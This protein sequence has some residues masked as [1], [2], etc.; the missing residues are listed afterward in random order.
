MAQTTHRWVCNNPAAGG[1]AWRQLQSSSAVV[2]RARTQQWLLEPGP[3]YFYQR[4]RLQCMPSKPHRN[5][6]RSSYWQHAS[7]PG[8]MGNPVCVVQSQHIC[9]D[10]L[11]G[12][13]AGA[14]HV[15]HPA[16]PSCR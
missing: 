7:R 12:G 4:V 16:Q 5:K 9:P 14:S 6:Q 13:R 2:A 15:I 11:I 10:I 1:D 8:A 3:S